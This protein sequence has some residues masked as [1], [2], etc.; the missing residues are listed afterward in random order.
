MIQAKQTHVGQYRK[1]GDFFREWEIETDEAVDYIRE[2]CFK[3]LSKRELPHKDVWSRRIQA[4][5]DKYGDYGYY[6]AGHYT[7]SPYQDKYKFVVCEP[8]AD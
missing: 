8:Y 4:G 5:G 7:L 1:Y 6:F 3:N 2:W